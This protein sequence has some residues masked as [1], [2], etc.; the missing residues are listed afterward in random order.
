M[1]TTFGTSGNDS[2]IVVKAGTFTLDGLSGVDT[3]ALGTSIRSATA[4][5][6]S[7]TSNDGLNVYNLSHIERIN[8]SN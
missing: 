2:W 4:T 1:A 3:L 5:G 7:L 8:F 6:Y